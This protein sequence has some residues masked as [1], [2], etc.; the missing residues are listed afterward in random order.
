[1]IEKNPLKNGALS[2]RTFLAG[3]GT[4]AAATMI[5]GCGTSS[6]PVTIVPPTP[7]TAPAFTDIDILNFALNLEYLEA[8]YYLR[9]ATG[10]GIPAADAGTGAGTV[11][12]GTKVA[13]LTS[14]QQQYLNQI[15]QDEYNHVKFLRA[16]LGSSAIPRPAID[17]TN[18]FNGL[19]S[20]ATGGKTTT[21]N[22]FASFNTWLIGGFVF[23]DVGVTAYKGGAGLLQSLKSAYLGPAAQILAVEAYHAA[24]LRTLI[25]G[26]S[27]PTGTSTAPVAGDQTYITLAD[28]IAAVR[29]SLTGGA[30]QAAGAE[31]ALMSGVSVT[32]ATATV[33]AAITVG[34]STI[35]NADATNAIA[36][37]RTTDQVLHIVYA[38]PTASTGFAYGLSSG[39]FFPS[40]LNGNIKQTYS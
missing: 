23:E 18:S 34:S 1:M 32:A 25:V 38:A 37:S 35:V 39:G 22:P 27:L 15:A 14:W 30:T 36:F 8:E 11:T 40:G 24:T 28:Q 31:V 16:A 6:T 10:A 29:A 26:T 2:R 21:F 17:L 9:A 7:P 19:A 3:A 13:G 33:P 20:I 5:V 12:G 4:A